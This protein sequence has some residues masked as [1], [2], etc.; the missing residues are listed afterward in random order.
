M[1]NPGLFLDF[2]RCQRADGSH[3]GTA[4]KC[5]KGR[6][7]D[8]LE[9]IKK[10]INPNMDWDSAKATLESKKLLGKGAFGGVYDWGGGVV[11]K[12]GSIS[13]PEVKALEELKH[14]DGIPRAIGH[15]F[16]PGEADNKFDLKMGI[17]AMTKGTGKP[18]TDIY[19]EPPRDSRTARRKAEILKIMEASTESTLKILKQ[20]HK[21][22]FAHYDL[23]IGNVLW[24]DSNKKATI[25]DFGFATKGNQKD[26]LRDIMKFINQQVGFSGT[27]GP[28]ITR[29]RSNIRNL[30]E[31]EGV[32]IT[33]E[34]ETNKPVDR[35]VEKIWEGVGLPGSTDKVQESTPWKKLKNV[36]NRKIL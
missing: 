11:V 15:M 33:M 19:Y 27:K 6:E 1:D 7:V 14:I 26:Q 8:A 34:G 18:L 2:T 35:I 3:Y 22:G 31:K 32:K 25:L 4:G 23:H 5:Q 9:E 12:M 21:A 28:A 20:I 29:I 30:G 24:D 10:L 17:L 16:K 13:G 36:W